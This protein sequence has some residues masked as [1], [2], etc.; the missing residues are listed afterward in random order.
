MNGASFT[1]TR[2]SRLSAAGRRVTVLLP[3]CCAILLTGCATDI[4]Q[5]RQQA[6]IP[7]SLLRGLEPGVVE[8]TASATQADY[9]DAWAVTFNAWEGCMTNLTQIQSIE[10]G[11][12][13]LAG[14]SNYQQ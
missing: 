7:E 4:E 10:D 11:R 9:A 2:G 14:A 5:V 12:K 3:L 6:P 8:D 13:G 1:R